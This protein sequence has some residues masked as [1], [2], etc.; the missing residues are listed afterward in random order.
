MSLLSGDIILDQEAF[1][2][3]SKDFMALEQKIKNLRQEI[4]SAV[5]ELEKGF[6]TPAGRKFI[7]SCKK[8]LFKPLNEQA[9]TI[10]M[11]SNTLEEAKREYSVVFE[12]YE[13]LL[14]TINNVQK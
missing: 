13:G 6:N 12:E 9:D 3:A 5:E 14:K 10:K 7:K 2:A 1:D 4:E 8:N 11:M